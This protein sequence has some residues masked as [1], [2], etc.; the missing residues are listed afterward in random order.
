MPIVY[1]QQIN[2]FTKIGVWHI[3]ETEDFFLEYIQLQYPINHPQKRLQ[4]LAGRHLL[5]A[6]FPSFPI[7]LI[8]IAQTR[9]P[10]LQN[11]HYHFSISHCGNY[12]A[13]II[14]TQN[15]VGVDIEIPQPKILAIQHKFFTE[16][17]QY[18]LQKALLEPIEK[19]TLVWSVKEA[20]FKW[21]AAGKVDFK[22]NMQIKQIKITPKGYLVNCF[23]I[24]NETKALKVE[25][26]WIDGICICWVIS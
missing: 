10:F 16:D 22:G 21:Y 15:R 1:Q 12:A 8:Q 2:T 11:D 19:A 6:L 7:E 24:K 14:S 5:K 18:V 4:H 13:A 9:K 25:N 20:I 23:F 26:I 17:E 3:T